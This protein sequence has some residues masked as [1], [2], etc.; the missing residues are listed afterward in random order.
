M[1]AQSCARSE[2]YVPTQHME[3]DMDFRC[4]STYRGG[5]AVGPLLEMGWRSE[6][7]FTTTVRSVTSLS[8]RSG[9]YSD[10]RSMKTGSMPKTFPLPASIPL[11]HSSNSLSTSSVSCAVTQSYC[12]ANKPRIALTNPLYMGIGCSYVSMSW[13]SL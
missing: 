5:C 7:G 13:S 3:C 12:A 8:I 11:G 4:D 10:H 6:Y 9:S 1:G 2:N